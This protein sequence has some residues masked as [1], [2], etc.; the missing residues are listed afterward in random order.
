MG[1]LDKITGTILVAVFVLALVMF[2]YSA[3][4]ENNINDTILN[5][6]HFSGINDTFASVLDDVGGEANTQRDNFE[7]E[8]PVQGTNDGFGLTTIPK[9]IAKFTSMMFASFK[10]V[11]NVLEDVFG[12]PSVVFNV[13]AGLL[14]IIIIVLGWGV[15][16]G[17]KE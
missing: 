6:P 11:T 16:K 4:I 5:D 17:A 2:G 3:Q 9:N 8:T 13:I 7:G 15:I 10:L 1:F 14:T 12:I